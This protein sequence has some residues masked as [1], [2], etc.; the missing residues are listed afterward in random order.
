MK[1]V[2]GEYVQK[3]TTLRNTYLAFSIKDIIVAVNLDQFSK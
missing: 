1:Q 3:Q 2:V